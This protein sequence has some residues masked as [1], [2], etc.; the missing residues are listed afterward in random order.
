[1]TK[2]IPL[3]L[4]ALAVSMSGASAQ[5]RIYFGSGGSNDAAQWTAWRTIY[6]DSGAALRPTAAARS[7]TT[8]RTDGS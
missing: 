6:D 2:M 1:M 5:S 7:R 4:L 3:A 8:L